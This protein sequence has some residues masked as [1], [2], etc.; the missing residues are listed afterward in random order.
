[1]SVI[2]IVRHCQTT[3]QA[4]EA[5]L[6][7]EGFAQAERLVEF[8]LPFGIDRV[9]SSPF[10]RAM[11]SLT[12]LAN[13]LGLPLEVD[14]RLKERLLCWPPIE[15]WLELNNRCYAEPDYVAPGGES[16]NSVFGRF[17]AVL[18]EVRQHPATAPALV[19]HGGMLS[20]LLNR[21]DENFGPESFRGLTNPDVYRLTYSDDSELPK[22]VRLWKVS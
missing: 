11:Q 4:P 22:A 20:V 19:T 13:H 2:Y 12:P 15:A 21:L 9:V 16:N 14:E 7:E 6:T 1:M 3:G 17:L 8:L 18:E 10:T 5:E